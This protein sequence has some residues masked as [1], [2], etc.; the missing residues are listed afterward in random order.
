MLS[1]IPNHVAVIPDGN[2]RWATERGKTT[3]EGH[4]KGF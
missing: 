2:R 4:K 3:Y 1:N